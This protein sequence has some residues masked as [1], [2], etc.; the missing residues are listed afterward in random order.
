MLIMR[1]NVTFILVVMLCIT[2]CSPK[3]NL[4][5]FSDISPRDLNTPKDISSALLYNEARIQPNDIIDITVTSSSTES[6]ALFN[7]SNP[8]PGTNSNYNNNFLITK[9]GYK[10]DKN[11]MTPFPVIGNIKVGG[12]T[13]DEAEIY[14]VKL[15]EPY[16]KN[17]M[18]SISFMNFKITVIGEV[19]HPGSFNIPSSSVN[20]LEALGLAG[21][22]TPFGRRDNVLLVRQI[23]NKRTILRINVN[24]SKLFDSPYYYLKQNDVIYIEPDKAKNQ[25]T[26]QDNRFIPL[27][28]ASTTIVAVLLNILLRK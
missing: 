1:Q 11:G 10:I 6:N 3:R 5:Y 14:L 7:V 16:L 24:D 27:V 26:S 20:V 4:V 12:L 15:L 21:D 17:P 25:Q 2:S 18:V 23:E 8:T 22:M 9:I 13:T 19:N 28:A